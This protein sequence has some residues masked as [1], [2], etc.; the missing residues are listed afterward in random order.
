MAVT[1]MTDDEIIKAL[2]CC[3]CGYCYRGEGCPLANDDSYDD[4]IS[5]CTSKLSENA[6]SLINRQRAEIAEYQKH[7]DNDIIYVKRVKAE[8]IK[9][10]TQR[11]KEYSTET[12]IGGKYKFQVVTTKCIDNLVKEMT[13]GT[14]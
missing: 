12:I 11:L 7:I 9:E 10:F 3:S 8:A 2:E 4:D 6:L 13:E 1:I 14:E 5:K